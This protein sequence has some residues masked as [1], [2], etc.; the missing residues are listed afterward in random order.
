[1]VPYLIRLFPAGRPFEGAQ[2]RKKAL[3][4]LWISQAQK[5]EPCLL[6][7]FMRSRD[8]L[9]YP[10]VPVAWGNKG[11][12][13]PCS[14]VQACMQEHLYVQGLQARPGE[15]NSLYSV[16]TCFNS[17]LPLWLRLSA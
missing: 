7:Q 1:M 13:P 4:F 10:H 9:S 17:M 3:L 5:P 8:L 6:W 15:N 12:V 14:T 11:Q 16:S 2:H